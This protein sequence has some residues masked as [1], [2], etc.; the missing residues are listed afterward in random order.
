L[1][2]DLWLPPQKPIWELVEFGVGVIPGGGW[3]KEMTLRAFGILLERID[4]GSFNCSTR[5]TLLTIGDGKSIYFRLM[6]HLIMGVL[7][8]GKDIVVVTIKIDSR[9]RRKGLRN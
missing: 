8:K 6:K 2:A 1:H 9:Y 7:E 4:V 3:F 5:I